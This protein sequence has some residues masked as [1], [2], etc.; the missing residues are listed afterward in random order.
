MLNYLKERYST[1]SKRLHASGHALLGALSCFIFGAL[2]LL[3]P[4]IVE[5]VQSFYDPKPLDWKDKFFDLCEW[6]VGAIIILLV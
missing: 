4:V 6:M 3:I 2:G 5:A 1:S